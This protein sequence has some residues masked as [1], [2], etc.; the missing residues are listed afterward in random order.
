MHGGAD[1][2]ITMNSIYSGIT[3]DLSRLTGA[4][5]RTNAS[6]SSGKIYSRPSDNP[7]ALTHA[8]NVRTALSDT[9]QYSHN[10]VYAQGWVR[11][12]EVAMIQISDRMTR[13]K[14]LAVQG[15]ND[16]LN[17]GDRR[18]I[19]A[20]IET[21]LE[22]V[23]ALGNSSLGGRYLFGGS[24]TSDYAP[25]EAPFILDRD[26]NVT[27]HGNGDG[28]SVSTG[29]GIHLEINLNG[30]DSLVQSGVFETLDLLHD[31]LM[32][33]SQSDIEVAIG[34]IDRAF[35]YITQQVAE[36]GA[37]GNT[38]ENNADMQTQFELTSRERL[39]DIEDTDLI[40]AAAEL[41]IQ[42]T[43]YQAALASASKVMG[44]SL[45]DFL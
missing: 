22:E 28:I 30:N 42:E 12:T 41:K 36:L 17:A 13:A 24:R 45:V 25:D 39:S 29:S 44:M 37:R 4:M 19:A 9:E 6:I 8:L 32:A 11:A 27:Y 40:E 35:Q 23:V 10:I 43:S 7:V 15:A 2:R 3:N 20:E 16:S 38:L 18:A 26:G 33:D 14:E 34:D 5:A 31:S 1:V 21:I